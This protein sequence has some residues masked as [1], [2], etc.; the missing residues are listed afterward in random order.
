MASSVLFISLNLLRA[1]S[2]YSGFV[3]ESFKRREALQFLH[4]D[5]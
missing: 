4:F 5:R 3:V 1:F 2:D